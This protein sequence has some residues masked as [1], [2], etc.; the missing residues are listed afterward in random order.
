VAAHREVAGIALAIPG[1]VGVLTAEACEVVHEAKGPGA[2]ERVVNRGGMDEPLLMLRSIPR[3]G[4]ICLGHHRFF[5]FHIA[6]FELRVL[7]WPS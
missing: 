2:R 6:Q 5:K 3:N 1:T 7:R 4:S